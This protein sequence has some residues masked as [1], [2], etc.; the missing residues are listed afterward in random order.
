MAIAR[1]NG[2]VIAESTETVVVEGHYYFPAQSV[3]V[4]MLRPTGAKD[5]GHYYS[6]IVDGKPTPD[7]ACYVMGAQVPDPRIAEHV[8]FFGPV[9][10]E[11]ED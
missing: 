3:R 4:E 2:E 7:C 10:V 8:E 5:N 11:V 9:T 6:V 1:L